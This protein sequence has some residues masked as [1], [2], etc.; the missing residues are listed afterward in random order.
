MPE[1]GPNGLLFGAFLLVCGF[2]AGWFFGGYV[3]WLSIK[4]GWDHPWRKK[5]D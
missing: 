1:L 3:M 2:V 4:H 5:E